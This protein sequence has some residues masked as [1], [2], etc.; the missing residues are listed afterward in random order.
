[1]LKAGLPVDH[2]VSEILLEKLESRKELKKVL[3]ARHTLL[4]FACLF[5]ES[6][7]LNILR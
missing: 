4:V 6:I 3:R 7:E 1:M 2:E 5:Y